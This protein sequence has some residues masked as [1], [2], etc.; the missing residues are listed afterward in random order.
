MS[1]A[2]QVKVA[3]PALLAMLKTSAEIHHRSPHQEAL[4]RLE[5]SFE[6]EDAFTRER[7]QKW[8]DEAMAEPSRP[9]RR[10]DLMKIARSILK[11]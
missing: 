6:I 4:E 9:H 3:S 2:I 1:K 11:K 10:G 5:R 8:I 7:D